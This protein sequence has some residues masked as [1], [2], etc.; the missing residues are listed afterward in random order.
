MSLLD[1]ILGRSRGPTLARFPDPPISAP[2]ASDTTEQEIILAGGCFWCV[3]AVYRELA[4]VTEVTSG[5][6]GGSAETARYQLVCGGDTDH[7]EAVKIRYDPRVIDLGQI[8]KIFFS[9]AH[10]PTQVNRQGNDVGRQ[11][12]SAIFYADEGQK[13]AAEAY[14]AAI[15][16]AG[17]YERPIATEVVPLDLF[18]EAEAYHQGYAARNPNQPYIAHISM[19][20]VAKL[21]A[22]YPEKLKRDETH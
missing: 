21:K 20:K 19:P 3:E 10:D 5:Y 12:R 9:V 15:D 6:S 14:I 17:V 13:Q 11:Y 22:V 4:G 16:A 2:V 8:L 1:G 7:A 18:H